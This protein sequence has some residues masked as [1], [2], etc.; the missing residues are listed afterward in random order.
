MPLRIGKNSVRHNMTELMK[1]PQSLARKR[2]INTIARKY[3]ISHAEAQARQARA[4]AEAQSR[5]K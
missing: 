1:A 2:A 4:I 3:G 5:K